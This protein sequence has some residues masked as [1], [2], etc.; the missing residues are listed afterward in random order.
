VADDLSVKAS[1]WAPV[2]EDVFER[3]LLRPTA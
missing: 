2:P 3:R 1:T